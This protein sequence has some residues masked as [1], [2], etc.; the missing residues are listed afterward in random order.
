MNNFVVE[1]LIDYIEDNIKNYQTVRSSFAN[2]V[3]KRYETT[4]IFFERILDMDFNM[5]LCSSN[6]FKAR[7]DKLN[8][9]T[10]PE[11]LTF[12][13]LRINKPEPTSF[14]IGDICRQMERQKILTKTS[15]STR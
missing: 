10:S 15:L 7:K 11:N 9:I 3:N 5:Y 2:E 4:A 6:Q 13:D 14:E 1:H 8:I 12:E